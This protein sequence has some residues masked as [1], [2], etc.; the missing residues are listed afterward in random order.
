MV[1]FRALYLKAQS[2]ALVFAS[3]ALF[4][5]TACG[6]DNTPASESSSPTV[7]VPG[8]PPVLTAQQIVDRATEAMES[9]IAFRADGEFVFRGAA[10]E[11]QAGSWTTEWTTPDRTRQVYEQE[12]VTA[13]IIRIGDQLFQRN[14]PGNEQWRESRPESDELLPDPKRFLI[15]LTV[16]EPVEVVESDGRVAYKLTGHPE[17]EDESEQFFETDATD[18]MYI[19]TI[20]FLVLCYERVL[21]FTVLEPDREN[22]GSVSPTVVR[23]DGQPDV[24]D[25]L[26]EV[27][28]SADIWFTMTYLDEPLVIEAPDNYVPYW[29]SS[30]SAFDGTTSGPVL[31]A[32]PALPTKTDTPKGGPVIIVTTPTP[33]AT[34]AAGSVGTRR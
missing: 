30:G 22:D 15:E 6:A 20:S 10:D 31:I 21:N 29:D 11:V 34:P 1:R 27:G 5:T 23:A 3:V 2:L 7:P 25:G 17:A 28:V 18:S 4:I 24:R 9:V 32:T 12:K 13:E 14:I 19:D 26:V 33:T 16:T 8:T